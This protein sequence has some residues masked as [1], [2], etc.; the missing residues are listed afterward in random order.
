[1]D[2]IRYP[3]YTY[4]HKNGSLIDKT[5]IVVESDP[6][7]FD[8]PLVI[9]HWLVTCYSDYEEAVKFQRTYKERKGIKP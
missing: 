5:F 2:H 1:M 7:Y 3:H 8:S 9:K 4:L 6:E